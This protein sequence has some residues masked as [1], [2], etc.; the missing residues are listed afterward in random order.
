LAEYELVSAAASLV[1]SR[2]GDC[3]P[4]AIVLGSGLGAVAASLANSKS[5]AYQDMPGW[6]ASTIAGHEGRLT[7]GELGGKPI[8]AL[9][10]RCH[11]Y[12]GHDLG[13]VT[14]AVRVLGV[15]GV[16][17][18]IL[19]NAAGAINRLFAPGDLMVIDDHLNL[20]CANPLEG[21]NEERFGVR[22][23]DMSAVYSERLRALADRAGRATGVAPRHG[24]YAAVRG[25]SYETPSEI[26][27]LR[28]IGA[29]AVGMSTVPE[30]IV[31]R[32]MGIE[33]LGISC[34]TNMAAGVADRPLEHADVVT[35]AARASHALR[36]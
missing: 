15:L 3:P 8:V 7:I 31:A 10:G 12:E 14:F 34:L 16:R 4:V 28:T 13:A 26:R 1:S 23:P 33:V 35:T 22:F 21:P 25:P 20:L 17:T 2:L 32:H 6:P 29:D 36:A 5:I 9:A 19:T 27:Y 24:V 30:A 11:L 18:L